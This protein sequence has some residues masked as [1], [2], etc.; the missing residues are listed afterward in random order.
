M[1]SISEIQLYNNQHVSIEVSIIIPLYNSK[2]YYKTLLDTIVSQDFP[3]NFIEVI[4]IDSSS[5]DGSFV[6]IDNYI[7]NLPISIDLINIPKV[8]F[9]HGSTRNLGISKSNGEFVILLTQD[10]LPS[11]KKWL[12]N[13]LKPLKENERVVLVTGRQIPYSDHSPIVKRDLNHHFSSYGINSGYL[14][15]SKDEISNISEDLRKFHSN[16]NA[17]IRK[18]FW[19]ENPFKPVDY[20]E[21][22]VMGRDVHKSSYLKAYSHDGSVYHSHDYP[23]IKYFRRIFDEFRGYKLTLNYIDGINFK[24]FLPY[25]FGRLKSDI[26]YIRKSKISFFQKSKY[27]LLALPY[28]IFRIVGAFLGS[29]HENVPSFLYPLFSLEKKQKKTHSMPNDRLNL[30]YI[31]RHISLAYSNGGVIHL[32]KEIV[33]FL[34]LGPKTL[35]SHDLPQAKFN[36]DMD[37][38]FDFLDYYD[39]SKQIFLEKEIDPKSKLQIAWLIPD[40]EKGS[41]GHSNIFQF[42]RGLEELGHSITIYIMPL[43]SPINCAERKKYLN[44]HFTELNGEVRVLPK[45]LNIVDSDISIATSWQT[46][47]PLYQISNT[48]KKI[49]FVQ[50]F[51]PWFY[52]KSSEYIFAQNTYKMGF[53]SITGGKWLSFVLSRDYMMK[54]DFFYYTYNSEIYKLNPGIKRQ[55]QKIFFYARHVTPRRGFELG[56]LALRKVK[57]IIENAHIVFAGW[58]CSGMTMPFEYENRGIQTPDQLADLFNECTVGLVISLTNYSILPQEMIACGLPVVDVNLENNRI[59]YEQGEVILAD[60]TPNSIANVLVDLIKN[61]EKRKKQTDHAMEIIQTRSLNAQIKKVE[62]LLYT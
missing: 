8:D 61:P 24:T 1:H 7:S 27:I 42:I 18:S 55:K 28:I 19:N 30:K 33:R 23:P 52:P 46:A 60:P 26:D 43:G 62:R 36:V 47:Y 32:L 35:P 48:K 41:G 31:M 10:A 9:N 45:D 3:N 16:V 25:I 37:Y 39:E 53:K 40:F 34:T 4:L 54:S 49:Y 14:I 56:V 58:D 50:D 5:T 6:E 13:I 29:R 12:P 15:L 22:Q 38:Y 2:I 44:E 21:D 11:S 57:G 20:C 51:E 17:A 59:S